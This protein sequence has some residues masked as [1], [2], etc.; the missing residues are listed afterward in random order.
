L[1]SMP[2]WELFARQTQPYRDQ[3]LPPQS[4]V[5]IAVEAGIRLG[6]EHHVGLVGEVIGLDGLGA[7]APGLLERS[8]ITAEEIVRAAEALLRQVPRS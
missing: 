8:G 5:R 1:V 6:W 3:I 4:P 2:S 7:S